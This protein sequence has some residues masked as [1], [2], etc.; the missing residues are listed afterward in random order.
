MKRVKQVLCVLLAVGL[1]LGL[2]GCNALDEAKAN[3]ALW[4]ADGSIR[5]NGHTY[6]LLP[7]CE[8]LAPDFPWHYEDIYHLTEEDVP[9]LAASFVG[10][11][12][13]KS[14]DGVFLHVF[15]E[16]RDTYDSVYYCREDRYED[17]VRRIEAGFTTD[18]IVYFYDKVDPQT[19]ESETVAYTLTADQRRAVEE[20]LDEEPV[21]MDEEFYPDNYVPL[22]ESSQDLL[23]NRELAHVALLDGEYYLLDPDWAW[24]YPIPDSLQSTYG[25]IMKTYIDAEDAYWDAYEMYW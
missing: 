2:C 24:A 6:R 12:I 15:V 7:A 20:A 1:C 9:V 13:D 18:K 17:I 8:E 23:F 14:V 10:E 21:P 3:H 25:D 22:M 16:D 5:M 11:A 4:Q 19:Y